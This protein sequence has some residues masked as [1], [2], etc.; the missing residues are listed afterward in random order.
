MKG[1]ATLGTGIRP[2]PNTFFKIWICVFSFG[3]IEQPLCVSVERRVTNSM[4]EPPTM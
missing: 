4:Y 1:I 3:S 2:A